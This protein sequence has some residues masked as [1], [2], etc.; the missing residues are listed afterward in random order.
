MPNKKWATRIKENE[1]CK[2]FKLLVTTP[3]SYSEINTSEKWF[4]INFLYNFYPP[5]ENHRSSSPVY[6]KGLTS[7]P[8]QYDSS[9]S[10]K[11]E[12]ENIWFL[13]D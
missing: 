2:D 5:I 9:I 3:D 13:Y 11:Q 1:K 7:L 12:M 6:M 10:K 8:F 4:L